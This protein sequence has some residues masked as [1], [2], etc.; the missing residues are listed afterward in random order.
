MKLRRLSM[1]IVA[2]CVVGLGIIAGCLPFPLGDPTQSK[3]DS[4][5]VGFWLNDSSDDRDLIAMYPFDEHTYVLQDQKLHQE[6]GKWTPRDTPALYKAWLTDVKGHRLLCL[7][8]LFQKVVPQDH[9]FYPAMLIESA[10][11]NMKIRLVNSDFEAIK[12]AKDATD[13]LAIVT[14]EIDNPKLYDE[15][16]TTFHRLDPD[17]DKETISLI[18]KF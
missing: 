13:E 8:P 16:P 18:A 4:K 15:S 2:A 17:R 11:A 1:V 12:S 9:N 7:E 6:D 3:V 10:D 14:R 5:L